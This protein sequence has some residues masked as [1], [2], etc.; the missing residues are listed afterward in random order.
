NRF[1]RMSVLSPAYAD[2]FTSADVVIVTDIYAS[3]TERIEGVTGEL[4]VRAVQ[5]AHPSADVRWAPR[6]DTL[7]QFVAPILENG[8]LCI[9]MGCGD[10]ETLPGEILAILRENHGRHVHEPR[11]SGSGEHGHD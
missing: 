4:V 3:G 1:N 11:R 7:A 5:E 2:C 10:V 6:R 8:D 9:S